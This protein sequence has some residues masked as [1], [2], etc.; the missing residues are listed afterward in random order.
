MLLLVSSYF[1]CLL[2]LAFYSSWYFPPCWII[3]RVWK[4]LTHPVRKQ[5]IYYGIVLASTWGSWVFQSI[6]I[7]RDIFADAAAQ[8]GLSPQSM[9]AE[10]DPAGRYFLLH[11]SRTFLCDRYLLQPD[12]CKRNFIDYSCLWFLPVTG[13]GTYRRPHLLPQIQKEADLWLCQSDRRPPS[14]IVGPV[15]KGSDCRSVCGI[16]QYDL[17]SFSRL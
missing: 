1:L 7:F 5:K 2:G 4:C 11:L 10:S 14:N 16:C 3:I 15:Q 17:Q 9:D 6:I 13:G 8:T 12:P